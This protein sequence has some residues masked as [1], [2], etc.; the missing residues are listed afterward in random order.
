M[1]NND[2]FQNNSEKK[3]YTIAHGPEGL[4]MILDEMLEQ[5]RTSQE[6]AHEPHYILY[7]VGSQNSIIK[8]DLSQPKF[9]YHDLLGRPM[10]RSVKKIIIDF[11][12]NKYGLKEQYNLPLEVE[13]E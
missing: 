5:S 7:R 12:W 13:N 11:L 4:A 6:Y 1:K 10:T 8:V 9:Y 2:L 3:E